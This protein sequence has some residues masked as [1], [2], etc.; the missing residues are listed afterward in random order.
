MD[1]QRERLTEQIH[2]LERATSDLTDKHGE[3]QRQHEQFK[4]QYELLKREKAKHWNES[5]EA[6]LSANLL[7][8]VA[9]SLRTNTISMCS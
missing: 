2:D 5:V 6:Q 8:E 4:A 7:I 1:N 9:A 3:L